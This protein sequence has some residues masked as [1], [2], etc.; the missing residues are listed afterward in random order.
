LALSLQVSS[1]SQA[2]MKLERNNYA[3]T[4]QRSHNAIES[5]QSPIW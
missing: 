4:E 3:A 5:Q 2:V 1:I